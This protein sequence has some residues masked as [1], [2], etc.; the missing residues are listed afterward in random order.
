[1]KWNTA[2]GAAA[3][4]A[5]IATRGMDTGTSLAV[6]KSG[7]PVKMSTLDELMREV[8]SVRLLKVDVEGYEKFVFQGASDVLNK[9]DFIIFE[10]IEENNNRFGYGVRDLVD[11]LSDFGFHVYM[12][13][14][15]SNAYVPFDADNYLGNLKRYS[16]DLI[17][18]KDDA[19]LNGFK[20]IGTLTSGEGVNTCRV[21][22]SE[23]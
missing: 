16:Y 13:S 5:A 21:G 9:T 3:V 11:H 19:L 17:G 8:E 2:P 20:W 22:N 23:V 18:T 1:M 15:P 14:V 7:V 10:A 4:K 12:F 6:G